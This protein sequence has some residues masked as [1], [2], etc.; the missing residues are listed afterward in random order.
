ML[1]REEKVGQSF[2]NAILCTASSETY[3][4]SLDHKMILY[5]PLKPYRIGILGCL[6]TF[7]M[8]IV[9]L[10]QQQCHKPPLISIHVYYIGK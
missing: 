1:K 5:E 8:S 6:S 3:I 10:R 4:P 9:G 7:A 2:V